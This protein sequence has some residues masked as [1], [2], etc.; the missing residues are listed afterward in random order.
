[1]KRLAISFIAVVGLPLLTASPAFCQSKIEVTGI[2][3]PRDNEGMYVRNNQ[4]QFEV[5]WTS[6]TKVAL[7]ANT[8]LLS[9]LKGDRF[10]YKIHSSKEVVTFPIPK[11][12]VTGIK[13]SRGGKQLEEALK[14]AKE[15]CWIAEFGLKLYFN[16]KPAR[17]QLGRPDDP[18]FIGT[19]DPTAKPRA[20]FIKGNKYEISLK[21]GGQTSALLFN[22]LS[23]KDCRPFINKATVLGRQKGD[24]LIADEIHLQPIGDQSA[25]DDLKKPRYLFIGDSISGNYDK[26]LRAAL[27]DKFNLHHPPTN[28]G[29][30]RN[31]AKNI[32]N[33]LGGY[34]QPGRHWDVISF[35]HGHWDAKN[36][37]VTYQ[38]NLEQVITQLEKT[39][40][41]LIWVTTCPVPNGYDPAGSL[42]ANGKAPGRTAGVMKNHLNPWALQVVK[43]HPGI[44]ICNQW[45]F[46][47]DNQEGI[48]TD[49]WAGKNVPFKGIAADA[50]G[51]L[52]GRHVEKRMKTK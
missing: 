5:S 6:K 45:Q 3:I 25:L 20:L 52:L 23:V 4:G 36:D 41:K 50:L 49:W 15:E 19:W 27:S 8:R 12:P 26:G 9:G 16:Q 21:K 40:A 22:L 44:S 29:P 38:A 1:M 51:E 31:G 46:V 34:D 48:Y 42:D 7:V 35:N 32:V 47:K 30:A 2:I 33:W 18:R 10:E 43:R 39:N 28:C 37:K 13:S 24:V 14:E 17:E 11:G